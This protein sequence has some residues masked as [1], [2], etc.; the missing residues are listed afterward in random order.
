MKTKFKFEDKCRLKTN[1]LIEVVL[2]GIIP[3]GVH[4]GVP[5]YSYKAH[6]IKLGMLQVAENNLELIE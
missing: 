5:I 6:N 2:V 1:P 3:H 4:L